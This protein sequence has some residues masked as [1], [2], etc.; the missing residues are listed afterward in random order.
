MAKSRPPLLNRELSWL[1]F[2]TRVLEEARDD[3][4]PLLERLKFLAI[5][6]SNLDE[7]FMVRVGGLQQLLE[8][9]QNTTGADGLTTAQQLAE[10]GKRT[11]A[12]VAEQYHCLFKQLEPELSREG[13]QR[14]CIADLSVQQRHHLEQV[15]E[16]DIYPVIT[17]VA[18]DSTAT[19]PL[20]PGLGVNLLVRIKPSRTAPKKTRFAV[21]RLPKSLSRFIPVPDS[22]GF[23]YVLLGEVIGEFVERLFPGEPVLECIP[24]R[25]TRN[26]D[27]SAREDLAG[28]LLAQMRE[29][30]DERRRGGCVR[31]EVDERISAPSL[32]F[33]CSGLHIVEEQV[34]RAPSPL[35]LTAYWGI[36][37]LDGFE[38]LRNKPW[39][40]Q[41]SPAVPPGASLFEVIARRDVL[42]FHPYESFEPVVR[43]VEQAADDP[44]VLSIKQILYRTNENSRIVA[45]LARAA[46]KGKQVTVLVE[47]KARFDEARNIEWAESLEQA[48][49]HVICGLKWLKV[50]AKVCIVVR[51]EPTGIRRYIHFG[52]GNYNEVTAT[53]YSDVGLLTC[54]EDLAADATAFF[55]AISGYSQPIQYRRLEAAPHGLKPRLLD[56]IES[57]IQRC[58]QGQDA[59]IMAKLNALVHREVIEALY[60]ASKAGVKIDL[61]IRGICCLRPG[62]PGLSEN[63]RVT[64]IVDRFLEHARVFY[65]H[66]GGESLVF[67]SSADWMPRN[68]D[69]RVELL[70]PVEDMAC[71]N[72]LIAILETSM[73]DNV[74][75]RR[76]LPDGRY[77]RLKP[78]GPGKAIR[79]QEVFYRQAREAAD[80]AQDNRHMVFEPRLPASAANK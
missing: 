30:L 32:Q 49:V 76:L 60:R 54:H 77:E 51:R 26:A 23:Q 65:F 41:P 59:R 10:I 22:K 67:L 7:F 63:I 35:D 46:S 4:V 17:P 57:E 24:F 9:G 70:V 12:L 34:Q 43:F 44:N 16:R 79:A 8:A 38:K 40:P 3:S 37:R 2:N 21:V 45:A 19:F 39:P 48:G 56:L 73:Q 36:V 47:L 75:A 33:L 80:Q 6:A 11:R 5:S 55:N 15:F 53:I 58:Q 72:R 74:K 29:V 28:D 42:L 68:L 50:H 31:L 61:N 27:M 25:I 71:R 64:S 18:V 66:H 14:T 13:I 69:R 62:V 52:T 20:L 1:E 78:P